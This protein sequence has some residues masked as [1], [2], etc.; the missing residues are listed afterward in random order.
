MSRGPEHS[1]R[2]KVIL[3]LMLMAGAIILPVSLFSMFYVKALARDDLAEKSVAIATTLG[4]SASASLEFQD[5]ADANEIL[6][7][8]RALPEVTRAAL[9][10]GARRPLAEYR[11]R[12]GGDALT[13]PRGPG[14]FWQP[15]HVTVLREVTLNGEPVGFVYLQF[16]RTKERRVFHRTAL[17]AGLGILG[18]ILL[19]FLVSHVLHRPITGPLERFAETVRDVTVTRDYGARVELQSSGEVG[20][21][22]EAFNDMLGVVEERD[23]GP[24]R[25]QRGAQPRGRA[26]HRRPGRGQRGAVPGEGGR[27]GVRPGQVALPRQHVPRAP[28]AHARDPELRALRG[29]EGHLGEAGEAHQV[30]L[31]DRGVRDQAARARE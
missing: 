16:A 27:G 21:L 22:V 24:G 28:H 20:Q 19:A 15:E 26:P 1:F 9:L 3:A 31:P 14:V 30:L 29:H 23:R 12:D 17:V 8:V 18:A 7:S 4:E 25:P 2:R 10:N 13:P 6:A 5:E 11:A